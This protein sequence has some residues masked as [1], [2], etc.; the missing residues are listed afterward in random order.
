MPTLQSGVYYIVSAFDP[1][2]CIDLPSDE[3]SNVRGSVTKQRG[4]GLVFQQWNVEATDTDRSMYKISWYGNPVDVL[5][6]SAT[7]PDAPKV[8]TLG[9][10]PDSQQK[11]YQQ[12]TITDPGNFGYFQIYCPL[13]DHC[14]DYFS[15]DQTERPVHLKPQNG[16]VQQ[17][18]MFQPVNYLEN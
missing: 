18:W 11:Y 1:T 8:H 13:T 14:V 7:L 17:R 15:D 6:D 4:N 12:W 16:S 9:W 10:Q 2:T 3:A 5:I